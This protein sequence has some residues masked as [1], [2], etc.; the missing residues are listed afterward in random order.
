MNFLF[1]NPLSHHGW[2]VFKVSEHTSYSSRQ[3]RL[4]VRI[5]VHKTTATYEFK[6]H[7]F[8]NLFLEWLFQCNLPCVLPV[9]ILKHVSCLIPY[10]DSFLFLC[11]EWSSLVFKDFQKYL[12]FK[13]K[14]F[15]CMLQL[16]WRFVYYWFF[17]VAII[18][19]IVK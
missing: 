9:L 2:I 11:G 15:F 5:F 6:V 12:F 19:R 18:N 3:C 17:E 10:I 7:F 14:V 1:I 4:K 16:F 13:P 8:T